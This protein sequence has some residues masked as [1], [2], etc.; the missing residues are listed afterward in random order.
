MRAT[1]LLNRVLKFSGTS[2]VK[3]EYS[4]SCPAIATVKLTARKKL[5]C[6]HCSFTTK[7]GYDPRWTESSRWHLDVRG[8]LLVLKMLRRRLCCPVHGV[9]VQAVPFARPNTRFTRDFEDLVA[10]LVEYAD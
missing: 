10:W 2:I 6:P 5:S 7:A 3:V 9:V 1:T 8:T 4:G